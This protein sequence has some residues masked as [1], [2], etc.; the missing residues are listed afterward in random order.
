MTSP[1]DAPYRVRQ[2]SSELRRKC[3]ADRCETFGFLGFTHYC[4]WSRDGRF[5]VKRRTDRQRLTRRLKELRSEARRRMHT[6]IV[7]QYRWLCGVLRGHFAYFGLPSNWDR[8]NAFS[9]ETRRIWYSAL[10]R[11]S[12]CRLSWERYVRLLERFPL[13]TPTVTHPRPVVAC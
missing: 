9:Q 11:R 8:L 12:Q 4:V 1:E 2:V 6:P 5:V 13:P 7:L 3:G 10:N